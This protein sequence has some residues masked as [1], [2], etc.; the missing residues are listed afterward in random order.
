MNAS[1]GSTLCNCRLITPLNRLNLSAIFTDISLKIKKGEFVTIMGPSGSGKSS[2]LKIISGMDNLY[3]GGVTILS[4]NLDTLDNKKLSFF[5]RNNLG[6][7][8]QL[9][10]FLDSL[11]ILDNILLPAIADKKSNVKQVKNS[12]LTMMADFNIIQSANKT[13]NQLSGGELQRAGICRALINNPDVIIADEPTGALNS[14]MAVDVMSI[15]ERIN[16]NNITILMVTHDTKIASYGDRILLLLDGE[17]VDDFSIDG[18][19]SQERVK[20]ISQK[21]LEFQF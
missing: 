4:H 18:L 17:I 12:A 10:D 5:R 6:F 11:T 1:S 7:I 14:K 21:Q 13:P 20:I 3:E 15:L 8:F 2:L 16:K 19:S 9:P